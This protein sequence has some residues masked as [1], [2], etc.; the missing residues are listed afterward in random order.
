MGWY[1]VIKAERCVYIF[2]LQQPK[3]AEEKCWKNE[4]AHQKNTQITL[5]LCVLNV[6]KPAVCVQIVLSAIYSISLAC[7]AFIWF[8]YLLSASDRQRG[9]L[10]PIAKKALSPNLAA[11]FSYSYATSPFWEPTPP[12]QVFLFSVLRWVV[13]PQLLS[14]YCFSMARS[15]HKMLKEHLKGQLK[16]QLSIR[17]LDWLQIA[18]M[19]P[20][21]Q[22]AIVGGHAALCAP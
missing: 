4:V 16:L 11:S 20:P 15:S 21:S 17:M 3:N 13:T 7:V 18:V 1:R 22:A 12:P 10:G 6:A 14:L 5:C 19:V 9:D 2:Q 8:M